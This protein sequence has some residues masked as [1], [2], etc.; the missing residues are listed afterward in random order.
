MSVFVVNL[1]PWRQRRLARRTRFWWLMLSLHAVCLLLA[2]MAGKGAVTRQRM[3]QESVLSWLQV[4]HQQHRSQW[5]AVQHAMTEVRRH[6]RQQRANAAARAQNL[7]YVQLLE[8][9][10]ALVP[11]GIW[12]TALTESERVV[13]ISGVSHGYGDIVRLRARLEREAALKTVQILYARHDKEAASPESQPEPL[14]FQLQA[15]WQA[16]PPVATGAHRDE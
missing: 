4:E 7:R 3:T 6:E 2:I 5:Q 15:A 13:S 14:A 1:L 8:Q 12:L 10:A 16:E 9:L 11:T